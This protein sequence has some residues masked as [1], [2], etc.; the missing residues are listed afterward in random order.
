[1][2]AE[3]MELNKLFDGKLNPFVPNGLFSASNDQMET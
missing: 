1:M 3:F 2:I